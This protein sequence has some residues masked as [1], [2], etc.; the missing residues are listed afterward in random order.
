MELSGRS[1]GARAIDCVAMKTHRRLLIAHERELKMTQ[2]LC[3]AP[4]A[5]DKAWQRADQPG[6]VQGSQQRRGPAH[7]PP[8]GCPLC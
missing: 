1:L 6:V 3:R 5:P 8:R 7:A 4:R 2:Q